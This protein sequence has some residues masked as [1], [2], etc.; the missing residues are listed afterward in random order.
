MRPSTIITGI[1]ASLWLAAV[2]LG[3]PLLMKLENS[4]GKSVSAPWQWP[5]DARV[6]LAHD[7]VTVVMFAHPQCPCTAASITE[8]K[9]LVELAGQRKLKINPYLLVLSPQSRPQYWERTDIIEAAR[10]IRGLTIV[11]DCDGIEANR[12]HSLTSGYTLAYDAHGKLLFSGGIT[13]SRGLVGDNQGLESL[14]G[15]L[16]GGARASKSSVVF[17]CSL[18]EN[19]SNELAKN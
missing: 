8:L 18:N 19:Q 16:S 3:M 10:R 13:G 12:F 9:G 4:P 2:A 11:D 15:V 7:G 6:A 1:L 5:K 14:I 17:G